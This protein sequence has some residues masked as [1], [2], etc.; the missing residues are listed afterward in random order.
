MR[1]LVY[2]NVEE[3]RSP[4]WGKGV[5]GVRMSLMVIVI[6]YFHTQK[7]SSFDIKLEIKTLLKIVLRQK[8]SCHVI[9]YIFLN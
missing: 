7:L 3:M 2:R 5:R 4:D 8:T 9:K 1:T 6:S